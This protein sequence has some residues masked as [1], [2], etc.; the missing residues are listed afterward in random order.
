MTPAS[1][2][3]SSR[4]QRPWIRNALG[5]L[6]LA[7][8]SASTFA[9]SSGIVARRES[10]PAQAPTTPRA[11][12][13]VDRPIPPEN[14]AGGSIEV[15]PMAS[16]EPGMLAF[17][18]HVQYWRGRNLPPLREQREIGLRVAVYDLDFEEIGDDSEPWHVE[19]SPSVPTPVG[20]AYAEV[21]PFAIRVPEPGRYVFRTWLLHRSQP[22]DEE[23]SLRNVACSQLADIDV[24]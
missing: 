22:F 15:H 20:V 16:P 14:W 1:S 2:R 19:Y 5:G 24:P 9:L 18:V 6:A 3:P 8:L 10:A 4:T 11:D 12:R 23:A 21:V 7:T 17:E 13:E